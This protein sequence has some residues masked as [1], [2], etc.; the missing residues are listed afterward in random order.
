MSF[1]FMSTILFVTNY[2]AL[3][4]Y[5]G[6]LP[7]LLSRYPLRSKLHFQAWASTW[8][9]HLHW[10]FSG[11]VWQGT[12]AYFLPSIFGMLLAVEVRKRLMGAPMRAC[13]KLYHDEHTRCVFCGRK[14]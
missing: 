11:W 8:R 5:T 10:L 1:L 4:Q 9:V 12:W 7:A 6:G 2:P 3:A 14:P 13:A